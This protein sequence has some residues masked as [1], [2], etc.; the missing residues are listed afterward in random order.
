MKSLFNFL[1]LVGLALAASLTAVSLPEGGGTL[2]TVISTV[3]HSSGGDAEGIL[4]AETTRQIKRILDRAGAG[5][6][7]R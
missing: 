4:T 5:S 7:T 1:P 3:D 2:R 6:L